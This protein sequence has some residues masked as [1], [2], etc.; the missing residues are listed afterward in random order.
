MI[1]RR[2]RSCQEQARCSPWIARKTGSFL[3]KTVG[4][5]NE[6]C[7]FNSVCIYCCA[8]PVAGCMKNKELSFIEIGSSTIINTI[9]VLNRQ[10]LFKVIPLSIVDKVEY[11]KRLALACLWFVLMD[12]FSVF[13]LTRRVILW[14][15]LIVVR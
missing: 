15:I 2:L 12:F 9:L 4:C 14:M 10:F 13:V 7:M 11:S 3:N 8:S 1:T 6:P 5:K